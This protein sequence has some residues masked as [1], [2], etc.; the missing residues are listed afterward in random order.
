[1][2]AGELETRTPA[3]GVR[4]VSA[5]YARGSMFETGETQISGAL[6]VGGDH[7]WTFLATGV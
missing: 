2:G 1:M 6:I 7:G 3:R 5:W 4:P